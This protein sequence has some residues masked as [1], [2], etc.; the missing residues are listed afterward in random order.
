MIYE[1]NNSFSSLVKNL[2][3][4]VKKVADGSHGLFLFAGNSDAV[5]GL[6]AEFLPAAKVGRR[7]RSG[8]VVAFGVGF[9]RLR[10]HRLFRG[11]LVDRVCSHQHLHSVCV[12]SDQAGTGLVVLCGVI[13]PQQIV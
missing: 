7:A 9:C 8:G 13:H 5:R 12:V 6:R 11:A 2:F 3:N 10:R 1:L 4:L